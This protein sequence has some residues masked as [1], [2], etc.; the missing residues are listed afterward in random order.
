[1][2]IKQLRTKTSG[3]NTDVIYTGYTNDILKTLLIGE[4][5]AKIAS[6]THILNKNASVSQLSSSEHIA[7]TSISYERKSTSVSSKIE[8]GADTKTG[9][10]IKNTLTNSIGD[11]SIGYNG[12]TNVSHGIISS[13]K[14]NIKDSS[15]GA[16][17][18]MGEI[19]AK[20]GYQF[21]SC[22]T[23][24]AEISSNSIGL[25]GT[26][27]NGAQIGGSITRDGFSIQFGYSM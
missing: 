22:R 6:D 19:R 10:L 20:Y 16:S 9:V 2:E 1:M 17:Y 7:A 13:G 15:I 18:D 8:I 3:L 5:S 11:I 21:D 14:I 24:E 26:T 23:I 12:G 27:G 25:Y 4:T